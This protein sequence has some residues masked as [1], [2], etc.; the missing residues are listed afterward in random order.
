MV[1]QAES[2]FLAFCRRL[3]PRLVSTLALHC[4]QLE[5]AEELAQETLVRVWER[6]STVRFADSPEAWTFRV[7]L[8]LSS[9]AGR[10][11]SL[12]RRVA[13]SYPIAVVDDDPSG[14]LA[15]RQALM[16]LAPRQRAAVLLRYFVDLSVDD[17]AAAMRCAP[18]TV[19][20]LT[21]QG[22]DRLR[23]HLTFDDEG[24]TLHD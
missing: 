3:H 2:E 24:V 22:I 1:D 20:A 11:R 6:W 8:N 5:V 19:K 21:S 4:G 7:A 15:V 12:E 17:T 13:A 23:D 9:S 10:R 16:T 18:G 14:P